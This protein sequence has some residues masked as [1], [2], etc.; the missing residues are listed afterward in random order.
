MSELKE[1]GS[2]RQTELLAELSKQR[3]D[4][5]QIVN[6]L[7]S[8]NHYHGDPESK[9]GWLELIVDYKEKQRQGDIKFR[10]K[11]IHQV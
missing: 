7:T 2:P 6:L 10:K 11:P 8:I 3:E 5:T 9:K 4:L 1:K